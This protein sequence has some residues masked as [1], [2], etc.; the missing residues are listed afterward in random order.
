M[1]PVPI[2]VR[3]PVSAERY[4][5]GPIPLAIQALPAFPVSVGVVRS[6]GGLVF[7]ELRTLTALPKLLRERLTSLERG[8]PDPPPGLSPGQT[9]RTYSPPARTSKR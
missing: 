2:D 6:L 9:A 3:R 7:N 4:T 8:L 1:G 5:T